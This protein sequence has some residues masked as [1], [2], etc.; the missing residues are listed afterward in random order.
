MAMLGFTAEAS[1]YRTKSHYYQGAKAPSQ[2]QQA[3]DLLV[4][5]GM[6]W[7]GRTECIRRAILR[8]IQSGG[9][10]QVCAEGRYSWCE[11]PP[12]WSLK[13]GGWCCENTFC[14]KCCVDVGGGV[15]QCSQPLCTGTP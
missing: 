10:I 13:S 3:V 15:T 2:S 11:C 1:L 6:S 4:A 9:S 7:S 14:P 12:G 5:Q 8:C